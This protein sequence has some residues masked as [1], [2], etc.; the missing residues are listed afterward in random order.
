MNYQDLISDKLLGLMKGDALS[1]N[2]EEK[3]FPL[4]REIAL[5]AASR[6]QVPVKIVVTDNGKPTDVVD[7]DP[8]GT[9]AQAL[10]HV[11]LRLESEREA[12]IPVLLPDF[13]EEEENFPLLQRYGHL[14][15]PVSVNR[16]ISVPWCVLPSDREKLSLINADKALEADYRIK[17]INSLSPSLLEFSGEDNSFSLLIPPSVSFT[18]GTSVLPNGRRFL[19]SMNFDRMVCPVDCNSAD[20]RISAQTTILGKRCN[21]VLEFRDGVLVDY[22]GPAEFKML[23]QLDDKLE[24]PGYISLRDKE[25]HVYLGGSVFEGVDGEFEDEEDLP[26]FFNRSLY[27]L[28]LELPENINLYCTGRDLKRTELVR[29]GFFLE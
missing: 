10:S 28:R 22:N 16:R 24:K 12:G 21:V 27:S 26:E 15:E 25:F 1:I 13:E 18:G 2:V 19:N 4:A 23:T 5:A 11:L 20:G 7:I 9:F 29:K 6:T 17:Y 3:D 14:S 8:E